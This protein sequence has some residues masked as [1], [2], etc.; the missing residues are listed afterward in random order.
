MSK[1][2]DAL[3]QNKAALEQLGIG[4][5][6]DLLRAVAKGLGPALYNKDA[7]TVSCSDQTELD[8][9]KKNFL[10]GKL[11]LPDG[12]ELMNAVNGV[13]VKMG[14]LGSSKYRLAFYYI[15]TVMFEK[16]SVYA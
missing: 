11:G 5:D 8:T 9:V 12:E 15:L 16:Q 4:V 1:F 3:V 2:D 14:P 7:K 10:M 6:A 13:C